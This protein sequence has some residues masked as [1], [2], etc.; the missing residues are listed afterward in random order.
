MAGPSQVLRP[1]FRI[2][3][4]FDGNGSIMGRDAGGGAPPGIHRDGEGCAVE[5][6]IARGLR[7]QVQLTAA[8]VGQG[9]ADQ[10]PGMFGHEVNRLG[11]HLGGGHHQIALVL[12][13]LIVHHHR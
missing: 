7:R 1:G 11:G 6:G 2:D 10:A 5:R 3:E 4:G 12:P 13:I 9:D 8:L